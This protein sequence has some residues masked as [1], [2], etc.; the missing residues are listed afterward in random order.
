VPL[1]PFGAAAQW[2]KGIVEWPGMSIKE[3][4]DV[5]YAYFNI[6]SVCGIRQT[7]E[8]DYVL[9]L[10]SGDVVFLRDCTWVTNL[11]EVAPPEG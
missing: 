8:D 3:E 2:I 7:N 11:G 5:R 6:Y 4:G 10:P 9:W 1:V